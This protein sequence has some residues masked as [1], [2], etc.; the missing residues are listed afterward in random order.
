MEKFDLFA[1]IAE[2]TEGS[3][4]IG[5]VG[6][7]RTG[8][9]TLIRRFMDL[10][11]LPEIEDTYVRQ[12]TADALPQSGAGRTI[13]TTEPK[14][15]PDEP[16]E[17][18]AGEHLRVKVRLVDCVGYAVEGAVGYLDEYGP[19][20]VRT[21]WFEG[22]IA[23]QQA[24]ELGTRKVIAEHSTMGLV[25]TTDGSITD[26]PRSAYEP[27]EERVIRELQELGKP[28]MVVLNSVHPEA[29]ETRQLAEKL[30]ARYGVTVLPLDCLHLRENELLGL[31]GELLYEFPLREVAFRLPGWV[32]ELD[33]EHWLRR[34]CEEAVAEVV[35]EVNKLRDVNAAVDAFS[36]Y[37]F[38]AGAELQLLDLGQGLADIR[39]ETREGLFYQVLQEI[40]GMELAGDRGLMR[41]IRELAT[42]KRAYDRVAAALA[43]VR[44][45]G[46]GI[47]PPAEEEIV[48]EE[49]ELIRRG[50]RFGIRLRATA[51][52]IHMIRAD[53]TTE[54]TPFIG[55][56]RQGEEF[57]R[58]LL[59]QYE[60][61]PGRIWQ[62]DFFGKP[63]PA[64]VR[65]G[66]DSKLHRMPENA[67]VKL[68][69]TLTKIVN[70]G[71]GGLICI[72]L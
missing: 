34:Q 69:E 57:A 25:V 50:N 72:L 60:K 12:R 61:Q 56:E 59:E 70:E 3:I 35:E 14:F 18:P 13:M 5:V 27:A 32:E 37:D 46:Y 47:V 62:A 53:I 28:F 67:Q 29:E 43:A 30:A 49:P 20:R 11:V 16:V 48:Y 71:S 22:E 36:R 1:D 63:L 68:Q 66:I 26:L 58:Y 40:T 64:L 39:V 41:A 8:K 6:P 9:S 23:F 15:V 10:V 4:Y 2:R 45:T 52:A 19:R 44:E 38:L 24:A 54:V 7:V 65:E 42:A 55:A 33:E 31:L 21:P 51:T 17:V